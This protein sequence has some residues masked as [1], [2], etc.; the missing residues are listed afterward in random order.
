[1][2]LLNED[3][4]GQVTGI[5]PVSFVNSFFEQEK[6]P[7]DLGWTPSLLQTNF[8]TLAVMIAQIVLYANDEVL[9]GIE[10]LESK[11]PCP[12]L[13]LRHFSETGCRRHGQARVRR[14]WYIETQVGVCLGRDELDARATIAFPVRKLGAIPTCACPGLLVPIIPDVLLRYCHVLTAVC[15]W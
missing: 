15:T 10:I 9:E 5:A 12:Y 7:Y 1:M 11:F 6:L 8:A 3:G 2:L 4:R 14:A 13:S